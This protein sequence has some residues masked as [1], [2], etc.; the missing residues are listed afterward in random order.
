MLQKYAG[1]LHWGMHCTVESLSSSFPLLG[2]CLFS[3]YIPCDAGD[4]TFGDY[5][6]GC[7][8]W[9]PSWFLQQEMVDLSLRTAQIPNVVSIGN[10]GRLKRSRNIFCWLQTASDCGFFA[11]STVT[12]LLR[13]W[14]ASLRSAWI[15]WILLEFPSHKC[16]LMTQ[17]GLCLQLEVYRQLEGIRSLSNQGNQYCEDPSY[18]DQCL[19]NEWYWSLSW[20]SLSARKLL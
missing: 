1:Q 18:R 20:R 3:W 10:H 13:G 8:V 4:W 17:T 11:H 16:H 6:R 14:K 19:F 5:L 15:R 2:G 7:R 9:L 12:S